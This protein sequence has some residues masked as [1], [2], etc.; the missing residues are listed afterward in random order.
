MTDNHLHFIPRQVQFYLLYS[1]HEWH[2]NCLK[3]Q[4]VENHHFLPKYL[5]LIVKHFFTIISAEHKSTFGEVLS[6]I[7][8]STTHLDANWQSL[9]GKQ[10]FF[11]QWPFDWWTHISYNTPNRWECSC[12][13]ES[14][15]TSPL[16]SKLVRERSFQRTFISSWYLQAMLINLCQIWCAQCSIFDSVIK[17]CQHHNNFP[18][19]IN[20]F[21][22]V[23]F[24]LPWKKHW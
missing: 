2:K 3:A 17:N 22:E 8:T 16:I 24:L 7:I 9:H 12:F 4:R 5:H 14:N 15:T 19:I 11:C 6:L 21:S 13:M 23:H 20:S 18:I 10:I 1:L